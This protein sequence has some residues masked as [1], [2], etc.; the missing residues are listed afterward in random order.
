MTEPKLARMTIGTLATATGVTPDTLRFYEKQGLL[1]PPVRADNGYRH[2]DAAAVARV[3][4]VRAAQALGFTLAEI[5]DAVPRL[6]AGRFGRADIETQLHRKLAEID[7]HMTQLRAMKKELL[8]TFAS[9]TC[10]DASQMRPALPASRRTAKDVR[11]RGEA[12]A[13]SVKKV[14][15]AAKAAKAAAP[16]RPARASAR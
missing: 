15:K 6:R 4:F 10:E 8:A 5:H 9:L 13:V 12:R 14:A 11:A 2:Y 3:R 7:A 16:V 1:D